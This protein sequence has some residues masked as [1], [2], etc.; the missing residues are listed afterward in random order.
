MLGLIVV[1]L[2]WVWLRVADVEGTIGRAL[3][4]YRALQAAG[5]LTK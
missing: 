1:L 3:E 5:V 4:H 2:C